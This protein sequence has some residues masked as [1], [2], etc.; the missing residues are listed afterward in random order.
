M[1]PPASGDDKLI[2][3]ALAIIETIDFEALS[4]VISASPPTTSSADDDLLLEAIH[5]VQAA[6]P[7]NNMLANG[8]QPP[9]LQTARARQAVGQQ[10]GQQ[11]QDGT[12]NT[13]Q[14]LIAE[15]ND[16]ERPSPG[17][18]GRRR[19]REQLIKLREVVRKM[20]SH[21]A[22]LKSPSSRLE[23][24]ENDEANAF[25]A[26]EN[27]SNNVNAPS[28]AADE[29]DLWR[30]IAIQQFRARRRA[31]HQNAELRDNLATQIRLAKQVETLLQMQ[32][33]HH[34]GLDETTTATPSQTEDAKPK[35]DQTHR[36]SL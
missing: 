5:A 31:E 9:R 21:L 25:W 16:A 27:D 22:S 14:V 3:E 23:E 6:F 18:K 33:Q 12:E 36:I 15:A 26:D 2:E 4:H 32:Q 8:H 28:D 35:P 29:A 11:D 7:H 20:E 10:R 17:S 19:V 24:L 13:L 1:D 30:N 34:S